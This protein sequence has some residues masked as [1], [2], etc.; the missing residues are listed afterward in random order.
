MDQ[1]DESRMGRLCI[2][3][4][5]EHRTVDYRGRDRPKKL[6]DERTRKRGVNGRFGA[7]HGPSCTA[8]TPSIGS[9]SLAQLALGAKGV[10]RETGGA[11]AE[12]AV[13]SALR[14][15][16]A[17]SHTPSTERGPTRA[18]SKRDSKSAKNPADSFRGEIAQTTEAQ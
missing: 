7:E 11:A 16:C 12:I 14:A 18:R 6:C 15:A 17:E 4:R 2:G 5:T 9:S 1:P 3:D 13:T 10:G 8:K